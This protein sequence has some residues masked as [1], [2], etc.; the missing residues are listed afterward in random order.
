MRV[1]YC[2]INDN[3]LFEQCMIIIRLDHTGVENKLKS[4]NF[5]KKKVTVFE[6]ICIECPVEI[7]REN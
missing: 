5:C 2:D 3:E 6:Y 1:Y 4:Y 7:G